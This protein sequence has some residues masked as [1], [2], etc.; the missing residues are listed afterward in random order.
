V[1][2]RQGP[3]IDSKIITVLKKGTKLTVLEE[4]KGWLHV[5][6]EDGTE[7]W[8][9]KSMTSEGTQPPPAAPGKPKSP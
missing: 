9:G 7:G 1:N 3:S 6:L 5:R 2:L 4:K 8:V